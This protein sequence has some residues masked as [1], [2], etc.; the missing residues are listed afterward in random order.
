[1]LK[2]KEEISNVRSLKWANVFKKDPKML[3]NMID[4]KG[5]TNNETEE[6]SPIT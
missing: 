3:W 2:E 1:M 5:N 6:I 4:W